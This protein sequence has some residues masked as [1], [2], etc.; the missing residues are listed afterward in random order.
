MTGT[1]HSSIC[2]QFSIAFR[3]WGIYKATEGRSRYRCWPSPIKK[4]RSRGHRREK[5]DKIGRTKKT[6]FNGPYYLRAALVLVLG[7]YISFLLCWAHIL[8][9]LLTNATTLLSELLPLRDAV[10]RIWIRTYYCAGNPVTVCVVVYSMIC[11]GI[12]EGRPIVQKTRM[13]HYK[14]VN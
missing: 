11:V 6:S 14:I 4:E 12:P 9:L 5:T 10:K 13:A 2:T 7:A 3:G 1:W 8:V